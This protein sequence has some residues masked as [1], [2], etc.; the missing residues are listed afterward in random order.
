[1]DRIVIVGTSCSGKS[2]FANQLAK[3]LGYPYIQLDEL[4]WLE[5]WQE[6]P[7]DEF[8]KLVKS[9]IDQPFWV[10]DGNYQ[11]VRQITWGKADTI[12]WLN[13]SFPVVFKRALF[14]TIKRIAFREQLYSG[15]RETFVRSFFSRESILFWVITT[16]QQRKQRYRRLFAA[17]EFVR[18]NK[19][20][21]TTP[22]VAAH[23]LNTIERIPET[24]KSDINR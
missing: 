16:H 23:F 7:P 14:R 9:A 20:E 18:L 21:F 15:N 17:D 2:T 13:Y 5:N 6:R 10:I 12:I 19:I 24:S 3:K 11:K 8:E 1:M 4:F 22:K